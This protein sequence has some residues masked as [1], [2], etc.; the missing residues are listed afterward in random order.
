MNKFFIITHS[1][2]LLHPD[3]KWF[4]IGFSVSV[5]FL[6]G[7][8]FSWCIWCGSLQ[9][10]SIRNNTFI[11]LTLDSM[12]YNHPV[13]PNLSFGASGPSVIASL[14]MPCILCPVKTKERTQE[15]WNT[16]VFDWNDALTLH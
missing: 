6:V 1:M 16:L 2:I 13:F 12:R 5:S 4:A 8:N 7:N 11:V 10:F 3:V 14:E 15:N 9:F